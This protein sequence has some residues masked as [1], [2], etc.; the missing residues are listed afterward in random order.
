MLFRGSRC[1]LVPTHVAYTENEKEKGEGENDIIYRV[2]K[3]K[4][5][6]KKIKKIKQKP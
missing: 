5:K 3:K 6:I 4:K 1:I 2:T